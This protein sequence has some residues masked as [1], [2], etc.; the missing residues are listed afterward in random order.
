M[1]GRL[2][3]HN[4]AFQDEEHQ[5]LMIPLIVQA[6]DRNWSQLMWA[7]QEKPVAW[8]RAEAWLR[9]SDD[10][11]ACCQIPEDDSRL[12]GYAAVH[13][14]AFAAIPA[15]GDEPPMGYERFC[16]MLCFKAGLLQHIRSSIDFQGAI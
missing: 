4:S 10:R 3:G 7:L 12:G 9:V 1:D 15:W 11:W 13:L 16:R 5:Q 2:F 14:A 8:A 6:D